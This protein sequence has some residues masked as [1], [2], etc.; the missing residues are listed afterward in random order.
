MELNTNEL[1][2]KLNVLE[3]A[4]NNKT[5]MEAFKGV[6]FINDKM[7]VS[8]G[9]QTII[10]TITGVDDMLVPFKTFKDVITRI[11]TTTFQMEI[12]DN[13]L[14]VKSGKSKYK[15]TLLDKTSFPQIK[16]EL[17]EAKITKINSNVLKDIINKTSYA[18]SSNER[19]PILCGVNF[20]STPI[21]D[22]SCIATDSFKLAKYEIECDAELPNCTITATDLDNLAKILPSD[23]EVVIKSNNKSIIF[24]FKDITYIARLL[25]GNY[26]NV[27]KIFGNYAYEVRFSRVALLGALNNVMVISNSENTICLS[28]DK[29][30]LKVASENTQFGNAEDEI[31]C[32]STGELVIFLN[33]NNLVEALKRNTNDSLILKFNG[34]LKPIQIVEDNYT[35]LLVPI[36]KD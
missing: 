33:G 8:N 13:S 1:L 10:S 31:E 2:T 4:Y 25:E 22:L 19:K 32:N 28:I 21:G 26:P 15:I 5:P 12:V 29:N 18:C 3:K 27:S 24:D 35:N 14:I 23:T 11:K 16:T 17:N 6:R 34:A 7:I 9:N 30:T 36:R 20:S